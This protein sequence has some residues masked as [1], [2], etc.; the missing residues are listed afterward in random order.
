MQHEIEEDTKNKYLVFVLANETYASPLLQ[1]REVIKIPSIKQ[2]PYMVPY[3]KGIINLRG[4]IVSVIDLRV[5]FNLKDFKSDEGLI[6]V[7]EAK[8]SLVGAIV[9]GV[10]SVQDIP[11]SDIDTNP[12]LETLVSPKFFLGVAKRSDML[13]N[14][15][16]IGGSLSSEDFRRIK[17]VA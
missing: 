2:V 9:D 13:I 14:L 1:I 12:A 5:K 16:D 15:I 8:G 7:I 3:F 6:L 17:E 10:C 11:S 4:Q